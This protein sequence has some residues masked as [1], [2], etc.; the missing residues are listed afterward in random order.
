M[1]RL[2]ALDRIGKS[3]FA[4]SRCLLTWVVAAA[5]LAALGVASLASARRSQRS[6]Q[7]TIAS[8]RGHARLRHGPVSIRI[9]AAPGTR[10]VK[11]TLNGDAITSSLR[12]AK[13]RT[14]TL[15]ASPNFGLRHGR[16]TLRVAA[17]AHGAT[18]TR[19]RRFV[20]AGSWP[21]AAAGLDQRVP[22]GTTV[23][24]SGLRS[25]L[26]PATGRGGSLKYSWSVV[27]APPP[28][29][30]AVGNPDGTPETG[31]NK[32]GETK[33][34]GAL[35]GALTA[36]PTARAD[37]PGDYTFRL[38]VTAPDG[39]KGSDLVEVRADPPPL[40]PVDTMAVDPNGSGAHGILVGD[41]F[42]KGSPDKWLQVAVFKRDTLEYM[43]NLS[44]EYDCPGT[45][46]RPFVSAA[47]FFVSCYS[48]VQADL[49][50]LDDSYL[51]IAANQPGSP[52]STVQP[53][54]GMESA[55]HGVGLPPIT[56]RGD[57]SHKLLRG[58][59][60]AIGLPGGGAGTGSQNAGDPLGSQ[61]AGDGALKGYLVRD[62][63]DHYGYTTPDRIE[64][65]TQAPGSTDCDGCSAQVN[66]VQ[67]GEHK[68][69]INPKFCCGFFHV[70]VLD[71]R[72]LAVMAN[73]AFYPVT[74]ADLA[75]MR[76]TLKAANDAGNKLV[77]ITSRGFTGKTSG[78]Y[79]DAENAT[80]ASLAD[81]I[82]N[83]GGTRT[84]FF[85]AINRTPDDLSYTLI[86]GSKLGAAH[87]LE[88]VKGGTTRGGFNT[89]P[90]KGEL[91]RDDNFNYQLQGSEAAGVP[92]NVGSRVTAAMNQA[93][94]PWPE[95]GNPGRTAAIKWIG[96]HVPLLDSPDPRAQYYTIPYSFGTWERIRQ[97]IDDSKLVPFE[98]GHGFT[99]ADLGWAKGE[100]RQEIE[101]L[102]AVNDRMAVLAQ[103]FADTGLAQWASLQQISHRVNDVVKV[104][105]QRSQQSIKR[106]FEGVNDV[107]KETPL[108]IGALIGALEAEYQTFAELVEINNG[109][110]PE[111]A[112]AVYT[113]KTDE[114]GTELAAR[115]DE[116]RKFLS[117]QAPEVIEADY[118]KL[119]LVGSCFRGIGCPNPINEWQ[120]TNT[121]INKAAKVLQAGAEV[122]FWGALL[123]AKYTAYDLL[124]SSQYKTPGK[125]YVEGAF[126]D[127]RCPFVKEPASAMVTRPIQLDLSQNPNHANDRYDIWAMGFLTHAGTLTDGYMMNIPGNDPDTGKPITDR[128]FGPVNPAGDLDKGGLGVY[129]E[130]FFRQY[131]TIHGLDHYPLKDSPGGR[132]RSDEGACTE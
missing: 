39:R 116:I 118:G 65:N 77:I 89:T 36:T 28:S 83:V 123:G 2:F 33:R 99:E 11:A 92:E 90:L 18:T 124:P 131:F 132:W 94:T 47:S 121:D 61:H 27:S 29:D 71:R 12:Q 21:L 60:S 49:K 54:I 64:F 7:F 113:A 55:L 57:P 101:W 59:Y 93:P 14:W 68:I 120:I 17:A 35:G 31:I 126:F 129:P 25:A 30:A 103:P 46:S 10:L 63:K 50:R 70:V 102:E 23:R 62:N 96:T 44:H 40:V 117:R 98:A 6:V 95:Q 1:Q 75:A 52:D 91:S 88:S 125:R 82:E 26:P 51:V 41:R 9:T 24:L 85:D 80:V 110:H 78:D 127:L 105:D 115:L 73:K 97:D 104:A 106:Y 38:T 128:V 16:N 107:L 45:T 53:P 108:E 79:T 72:T 20:L 3:A 32:P 119:K 114:L 15:Q 69:S 37:E 74:D 4:P 87:G 112:A 109:E 58:T 84:H 42:I 67:V 19:V 66:V 22:V 8:P 81:Q 111:N 48:Q 76:D 34:Q 130:A 122:N 43:P 100:L 5:A 86:G 13:P 56:Y